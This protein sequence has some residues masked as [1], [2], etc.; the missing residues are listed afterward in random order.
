MAASTPRARRRP[1]HL[2][3]YEDTVVLPGDR[4]PG[5]AQFAPWASSWA[6]VEVLSV[7]WSAR[8]RYVEKLQCCA[9]C[10]AVKFHTGRPWRSRAPAIHPFSPYGRKVYPM[11]S[12][13][14]DEQGRWIVCDI[15]A[16]CNK[17]RDG[18]ME[19]VPSYPPEYLRGLLST[20][21][22]HLEL[23][24]VV[25]VSQGLR[26]R[27]LGYC[28]GQLVNGSV[29]DNPLLTWDRNLQKCTDAA[30]I[31]GGVTP[32]LDTLAAHNPLVSTCK[33]ML[34]R[35][36]PK[37]GNTVLGYSCLRSMLSTQG[38][39]SIATVMSEGQVPLAMS[40]GLD[41]GTLTCSQSSYRSGHVVLRADAVE[42][43]GE[44]VLLFDITN[45]GL[46]TEAPLADRTMEEAV[47]PYL[48][49]YGLGSHKSGKLGLYCGHRAS[50]LFSPFTLVPQY[51]LNLYLMRQAELLLRFS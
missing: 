12:A 20:D 26:T 36:H 32:L 14:L 3:S 46:C 22:M 15:C 1:G 28:S 31:A 47:H 16:K 45:S 42:A 50:M 19:H 39:R 11:Q 29:L 10:G 21:P 25:D 5:G 18:R 33:T 27:A 38:A 17:A 8:Q 48:F 37:S 23:L 2:G 51:M 9:Y 13:T 7:S 4:L 40:L 41:I 6:S 34:E 43:R 44:R 35:E 30:A 24:S 49:P